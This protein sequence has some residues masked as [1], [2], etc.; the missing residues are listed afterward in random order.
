[1]SASGKLAITVDIEDWYH[2]PSVTGSPFAQYESVDTFFTS[3]KG[4]YDYLTEPTD[5]VLELLDELEVR[6]TFFVVADVV[7][8]Y[9][10]LVQR[11][12]AHGHEVACHGLHHG[13]AISPD[14]KAPLL[15]KDKFLEQTRV[16]REILENATGSAVDG[17]RAP[18]AYIAGWM[19][20]CLEELGFAYDSSVSANSLYNKSD[21]SLAGVATTPYWPHRGELTPGPPRDIVEIPWPSFRFLLRFPT[22]GGPL[23]RFLGRRYIDFGLRASLRR[24]DAV[25]YFHPI[26][27][28]EEDFP[29]GPLP[30]RPFFWSIKGAVVE[31]R[32][33]RLVRKYADRSTT[34]GEIA[35]RTALK[36]S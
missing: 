4:R 5:R 19:I 2:I 3:W 8:R 12:A 35:L 26:D 6:S 27:I 33:R 17:Y 21:S 9:R 14:T 32:I 36:A 28:S 29:S 15:T 24:G 18:A 16:A 31:N 22:G 30:R 25:F 7:G 10:G 1:L 23:L 34:C 13:C 20:D 11:I